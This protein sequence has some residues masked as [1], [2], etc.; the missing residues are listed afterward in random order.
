VQA[1]VLKIKKHKSRYY[2]DLIEYSDTGDVLAQARGIVR[3]EHVLH[4]FLTQTG[5]TLPEL[6][7]K[8]LMF[9]ARCNFHHQRGF[10]LSIGAISAEFTIGQA[11]KQQYDILAHL[12]KT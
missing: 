5:L 4:T 2:L 9:S 12:K 11:H 8:S 1:E 7:G 6:D 10:S 3:D